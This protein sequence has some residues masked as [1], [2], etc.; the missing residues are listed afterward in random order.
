MIRVET[1]HQT[2]CI[3]KHWLSAPEYS[4]QSYKYKDNLKILLA[5]IS[6][7]I[8]FYCLPRSLG[9]SKILRFELLSPMLHL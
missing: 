4:H 6:L 3:N 5:V 8:F 2:A 9:E 1:P 7:D